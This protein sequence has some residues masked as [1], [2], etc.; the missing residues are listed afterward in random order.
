[1]RP[2]LLQPLFATLSSLTGIGDKMRD[3]LAALLGGRAAAAAAADS[4]LSAPLPR[5]IDLLHFP[6]QTIIDRRGHYTIATLP[7]Q[8][9]ASLEVCIGRHKAPQQSRK[10]SPYKISAHDETGEMDL[11]F[12]RAR[13]D[14]LQRQFPPGEK[15]FISGKIEYF[16]G[17]PAMIHPDYSVKPDERRTIPPVEP[18]YPLI[19]GLTNRLI[20]KAMTQALQRLPDLPEWLGADLLKRENFPSYTGALRQLHRPHRPEDIEPTSPARRRLAYD[21]LLAGQIALRLIRR[22]NRRGQGANLPPGNSYTQKLR[23]ALPFKLTAAQEQGFTEIS[24]DLA[25]KQRMLRLLQGD[26]GSGKTVIALLAMA[27]AAESGAQAALMVPTEILAHQHYA[28][29]APMAEQAGLRAVLLTGREKGNKRAVILQQIAQGEVQFIIGTHALFQADVLYHRLA[30]AVIDEQHRFGVEQRLQLLAKGQG[31]NILVMT[32]TPIP[33][34]LVLTAYGDMDISTL[35]EKPQG[36]KPVITALLSMAKMGL[37]LASVRQALGRGDKIYWIC[38]LVEGSEKSDLT[39]AT[40]R[41]AELQALLSARIGLVHGKMP[42]AEKD[43]VMA[44][45]KSGAIRLLVATTVV[46][47]GVDVTDASIM[48]IEH[49]ERFGLAQLHQLRGRVGRGEKVSSCTLLY[50]EPLSATARARLGIMRETEDGFRLAEED[51]RL[52]GEGDIL[53]LRQSG[54]PDFCFADS[55]LHRDLMEIAAK[56]AR[57]L[58]QNEAIWATEKGEALRLLL[59]LFRQDNALRLLQSG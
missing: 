46:E 6:P 27:Q 48:I 32:A 18:V 16:N 17:L 52:R 31:V 47:V 26:V 7:A 9:I 44:A 39:A 28:A 25:R 15:R 38:P 2:V 43:A 20:A 5:L 36:R 35:R 58:V 1:M 21:E 42:A 33:R 13:G 22:Q 24:A 59:C 49:A 57:L 3:R 56:N 14:W 40:E 41:F 53:G 30:L 45:F 34:S 11:V 4:P 37:L 10:N 51:L 54:L 50:K 55:R 29:L 12:F 8:K 19:A 23:A